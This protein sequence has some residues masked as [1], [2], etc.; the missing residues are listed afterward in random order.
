MNFPYLVEVA[1]W[2]TEHL[3]VMVEWLCTRGHLF[4]DTIL[5]GES[6]LVT[7]PE[8]NRFHALQ[9]IYFADKNEAIIFKLT[10]GGK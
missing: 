1:L 4:N 6:R 5:F 3:H 9:P 10:W 8:T 7:R 2:D